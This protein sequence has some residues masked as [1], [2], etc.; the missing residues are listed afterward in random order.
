MTRRTRTAS[1]VALAVAFVLTA[2]AAW[3]STSAV[4][5]NTAGFQHWRTDLAPLANAQTWIVQGRMLGNGACRYR[6]TN[7]EKEVPA[8][9]WVERTVALDPI[10][11]RK[12][13]EAGNPTEPSQRTTDQSASSSSVSSPALTS[14]PAPEQELSILSTQSAWIRS[15]WLDVANL[16]VNDDVTQVNWTSNGTTVSNGSSNGYFS[17]LQATGWQKLADSNT[18]T[19]GPGY[20]Y[21]QGETTSSFGNATFCPWPLPDVF[22]YYFYVRMW[23]HPNGTATWSQSSDSI[24]ECFPFHTEKVSGYGP[25]PGF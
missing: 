13:V 11:C 15:S 3:T 10:R 12:L 23:G 8:G 22:T 16:H 20:S 9:G 5:L 1:A 24:D 4:A 2:S 7:T 21:I 25:F 6:N 19:Y 17:W 14:D 18:S